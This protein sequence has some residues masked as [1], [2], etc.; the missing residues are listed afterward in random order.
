M[1]SWHSESWDWLPLKSLF[2]VFQEYLLLEDEGFVDFFNSFLALP[3]SFIAV[4][5]NFYF[6]L[7][8][9][10]HYTHTKYTMLNIHTTYFE[11]CVNQRESLQGVG[12][13]WR[14][15]RGCSI[16]GSVIQENVNDGAPKELTNLYTEWRGLSYQ[17][18]TLIPKER[19]L[20]ITKFV[21][22]FRL[23]SVCLT[24]PL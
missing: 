3:V 10:A 2:L 13:V 21:V 24:Q 7:D 20:S 1:S 19:I 18:V 12:W 4:K 14:L 15:W 11:S 5:L 17:M 9:Q 16:A 23:E 6:N 8:S 22:Y